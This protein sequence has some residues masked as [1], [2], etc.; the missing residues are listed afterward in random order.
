MP[1]YQVCIEDVHGDCFYSDSDETDFPDITDMDRWCAAEA[2][3]K[4]ARDNNI[5]PLTIEISLTQ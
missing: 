4:W 1:A 3:I 2:A 5:A